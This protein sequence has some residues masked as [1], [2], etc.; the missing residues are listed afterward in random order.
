[1]TENEAVKATQTTV[2]SSRL[3]TLQQ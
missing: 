3:F 2:D 1:M